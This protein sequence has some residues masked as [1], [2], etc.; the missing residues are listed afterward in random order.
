MKTF[1][2]MLA[3]TVDNL[4]DLL[5]PYLA[6]P[7]IDG[8]RCTK[9]GSNPLTRSLEDIPNDYIRKVLKKLSYTNTDGELI[10]LDKNDNPNVFNIVSSEIMSKSG[11]PN[12][13][14]LIFDEIVDGVYSTRIANMCSRMVGSDSSFVKVLIPVLIKNKTALKTYIKKMKTYGYEGVILRKPESLYKFGRSTLK[15]GGLLRIIEFKT[16]E[17]MVTGFNERMHNANEAKISKTGY[18]KRSSHKANMK[19][20]NMVGAIIVSDSKYGEIAIGTGFD[21]KLAKEM[22]KNQEKYI[23]NVL[24]YKFKPYGIKDKPRSVSFVG[25]RDERDIG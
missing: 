14:Y 18:M 13:Q 21:N 9:I 4:D 15:E 17:A 19:G 16:R 25:F 3:C 7:K 5:Y 22:W 12:F 8:I 24:K 1:R 23:N 6:T 10:T 2:P 11:K 20:M